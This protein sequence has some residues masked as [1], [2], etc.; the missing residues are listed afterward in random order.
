MKYPKVP[1]IDINVKQT[2]K[3]FEKHKPS[4]KAVCPHCKC[5]IDAEYGHVIFVCMTEVEGEYNGSYQPYDTFADNGSDYK[6]YCPECE[7]EL[8]KQ[9]V[10]KILKTT[11]GLWR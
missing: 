9:Q 10:N 6:Y 5:D 7:L 4:P 11:D 8:T 1:I 3:A 2:M